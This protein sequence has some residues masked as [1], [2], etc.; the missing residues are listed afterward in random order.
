MIRPAD[1]EDTAGA[2]AAAMLRK[3]GPTAIILTRQNVPA[4]DSSTVSERRQGVIKGGYIAKKE[5]GDLKLILLATG[6]ELQHAMGAAEQIGEGVRVVSLPCFE[7][8]ERQNADYIE[9]VLPSTCTARV[10]VEAG[11]SSTWGQYVGLTG[12]TVCI[13]R[14]GISAPGDTVMAELGMTA[15]N[16]A[17]VAKT[18]I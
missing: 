1:A 8:F 6:S 2:F 9:S 10:A 14:F 12:K 18:L 16:V 4:H 5:G 17:Q 3:D 15:D 13:D 7:R 11:V